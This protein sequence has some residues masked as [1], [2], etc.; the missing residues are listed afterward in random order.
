VIITSA[1]LGPATPYSIP[2]IGAENFFTVTSGAITNAEFTETLFVGPTTQFTLILNINSTITPEPNQ[3]GFG[4]RIFVQT[5]T[6]TFQQITATPLPAALPLFA[7]ALGGL[8]LLGM[9]RKRKK[10]AATAAA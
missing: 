7:T 2:L 6:A 8:G 9:R 10:I 4:T 1:P 5:D 3:A